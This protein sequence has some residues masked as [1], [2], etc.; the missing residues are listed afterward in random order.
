MSLIVGRRS[1][2]H[3]CTKGTNGLIYRIIRFFQSPYKPHFRGR[4]GNFISSED[5]NI[6]ISRQHSQVE[7]HLPQQQPLD[8][9]KNL[10]PPSRFPER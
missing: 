8:K 3:G 9:V 7:L 1:K 10:Q 5:V 6:L 4:K 2:S